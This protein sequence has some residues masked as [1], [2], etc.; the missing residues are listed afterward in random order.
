MNNRKKI[1]LITIHVGSNFGSVLQTIASARVLKNLGC[2]VTI[3][4]YIPNRVTYGRLLRDSLG[5][6]SDCIKVFY[7]LFNKYRNRK[8]YIGYLKLFCDL[9]K[10]IY[11]TDN[12]QKKCPQADIYVTG[13]DQVWNST[14]NEGIDSHYFFAGIE[15]RKLAYASSIG[16]N[17]LSYEDKNA[18]KHYLPEY[19]G[20]S[21]RENSAVRQLEEL[22]F[23]S[24]QL[25]DPTFM[26][27]KDDWKEYSSGRL[28][29]YPYLLVYIPYNIKDKS[30]I[31]E[32][33]RKIASKR[34]LKVVTFSW[35]SRTDPL[36]DV[37]IKYASPGDFVSYML[38]ADVV[39]T[40]SFHGTAFSIN[41]NKDFWVYMPTAFSTRIESL[42]ELC[43]LKGRLLDDVIQDDWE[44]KWIDYNVVNPI[45]EIKRNETIDFLSQFTS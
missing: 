5:T 39:I 1:S 11:S 16:K 29:S 14:H 28:V 35:N 13:S 44:N 42:L 25:V 22:G 26:L 24:V 12:Y 43:E 19:I 6:L 4:N 31:Y 21:V 33:A 41:L 17:S 36:A 40:N 18:F 32:T 3:V 20:I 15:G 27:T 9:S 45:L 7:R 30:V 37:T 2:D 8:I 38:Y 23:N 34:G 10:T